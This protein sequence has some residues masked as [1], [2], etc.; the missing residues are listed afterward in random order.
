LIKWRSY[1]LT[2]PN[3]YLPP[4]EAFYIQPLKTTQNPLLPTPEKSS[5]YLP[6]ISPNRSKE[7]KGAVQ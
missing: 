1:F 2:K 6:P 3:E 7:V 5:V 4:E